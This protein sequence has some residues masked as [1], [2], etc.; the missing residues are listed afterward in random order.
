MYV[1]CMLYVL[2]ARH[3]KE[4]SFINLIIRFVETGKV[5]YKKLEWTKTVANEKSELN[6]LLMAVEDGHRSQ[7]NLSELTEI[8]VRP[9]QR[10]L[11][12][13]LSYAFHIQLH[14]ELSETDFETVIEFWKNPIFILI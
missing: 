13:N 12:K 5:V 1:D 8:S 10:M 14:K 9:V 2:L 6:G 7:K 11:K 3:Y 4:K